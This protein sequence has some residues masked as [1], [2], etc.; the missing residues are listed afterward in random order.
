[1]SLCLPTRMLDLGFENCP[2]LHLRESSKELS[3]DRYV[4]LSHCWG[5]KFVYR[6][7]ERNKEEFLKG[8]DVNKLPLTFREAVSITGKLG[9]RYLWIDSLCIIQDSPADWLNEASKMGDIYRNSYLNLAASSARNG[10]EGLF[11]DKEP[12]LLNRCNLFKDVSQTNCK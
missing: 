8:I 7:L 2:S 5:N 11:R 4:T 9:V 1:M 3:T 10:E 6:L 12:V